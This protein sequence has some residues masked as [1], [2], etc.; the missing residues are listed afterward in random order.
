MEQVHFKLINKRAAPWG[1]F[2]DGQNIHIVW[3]TPDVCEASIDK[4]YISESMKRAIKQDRDLGIIEVEGLELE[5]PVEQAPSAFAPNGSYQQARDSLLAE[6]KKSS[7]DDLFKE[8]VESILK[9]GASKAKKKLKELAGMRPATFFSKAI[10]HEVSHKNRKTVLAILNDL[11][12]EATFSASN[13][14]SADGLEKQ[15]YEMVEDESP[16]PEQNS[17][18]K[19]LF[20]KE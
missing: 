9:L 4:R 5:E 10:D 11:K 3:L 16:E 2:A 19:G 6:R 15:I 12:I 7:S 17:F 18:I 8:E 20:D 1:L 14:I 13:P